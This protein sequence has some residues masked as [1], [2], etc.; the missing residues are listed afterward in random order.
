MVKIMYDLK[1]HGERPPKNDIFN[2]LKAANLDDPKYLDQINKMM[3]QWREVIMADSENAPLILQ[4]TSENLIQIK[5][6]SIIS[7]IRVTSSSDKSATLLSEVKFA[8]SHI[9]FEEV[10][11]IPYI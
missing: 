7:L 5:S 6:L 1:D 3:D 10:D 8:A 11:P 9:F 2:T 4:K